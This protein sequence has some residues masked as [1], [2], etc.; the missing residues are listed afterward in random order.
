MRIL[1]LVLTQVFG[2]WGYIG[3]IVLTILG[4]VCNRTVSHRSYI[5][6]LIPFHWNKLKGRLVRR[7][8]PGALENKE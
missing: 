6:P 8:L 1:C 3:G 7:R 5:Y 4:V 2:L